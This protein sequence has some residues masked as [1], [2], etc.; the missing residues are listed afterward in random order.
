MTFY[1]PADSSIRDSS[2]KTA[3]DYALERGMHYCALLIS[4]DE[5]L[6]CTDRSACMHTVKMKVCIYCTLNCPNTHTKP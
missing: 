2:D 3:L 1:V 6:E 4:K 5:V